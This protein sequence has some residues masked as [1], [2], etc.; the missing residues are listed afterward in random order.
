MRAGSRGKGE[1]G[2][3][4]V[5]QEGHCDCHS[6][7]KSKGAKFMRSTVY[8]LSLSTENNKPVDLTVTFREEGR[9][10]YHRD[11]HRWEEKS[12]RRTMGSRPRER[13]APTKRERSCSSI[14]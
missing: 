3:C 1:E 5:R 9:A 7:G 10:R 13:I 14:P 4:G 12:G 11:Y 2:K 8:C 6:V